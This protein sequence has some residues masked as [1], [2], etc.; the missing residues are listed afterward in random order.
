[1]EKDKNTVEILESL[2]QSFASV[3]VECIDS[4]FQKKCELNEPWSVVERLQGTFD[5]IFSLGS[6]NQEYQAIMAVGITRDHMRAFIGFDIDEGE[7]VDAFGE[8]TNNYCALI[9]DIEKY[10]DNFGILRAAIPTHSLDQS[11]FPRVWGVNGKVYL[12]DKWMYLG[13]SIRKSI[14]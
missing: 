7:M 8:F 13:Y 2:K 6:S 10:K 4:F 12:A 3:A 11:F 9:N 1:M 14:M 5:H